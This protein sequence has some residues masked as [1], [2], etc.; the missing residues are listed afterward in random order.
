[1]A[2]NNATNNTPSVP[3][4][5]SQGGTGTNTLTANGVIIGNTTSAVNVT[6]AG[7]TGQLFI[8]TTSANPAFG[9][10]A[11]A[12]FTFTTSTAST[13]RTLTV[14]N[15]N[16]SSSSSNA[17][18]ALSVGGTSSGDP[19]ILYTAGAIN[20]SIGLDTDGTSTNSQPF[21]IS[22]SNA[23]G[24]TNVMSVDI[25]GTVSLPLTPAFLGVVGSTA[26]AV[27]GDG[28]AYTIISY[29]SQFDQNSNF[30]A[31]SGVFT[32]PIAGI[33]YFSGTVLLGSVG[34]AHTAETFTLT[35]STSIYF[36]NYASPGL[37]KDANNN[38][39]YNVTTFAKMS[40]ADT[41]SLIITVSNSTKTVDV[42][43]G[44]PATNSVTYFSGYLA[45]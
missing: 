34:V 8:G 43:G 33:Y 42:V 6:T 44:T 14:S 30:N 16:N 23:L 11:G 12:D 9:S 13:T 4:S 35:T 38:V 5:V 20:W 17:T 15:T 25:N 2:T 22:A 41:A 10:S 32:A 26:S 39:S 37:M 36:G 28:T 45:C 29:T 27:T 31:S 19:S 40:A 21:V 18:V 3:V 24:T 7:T 1:M